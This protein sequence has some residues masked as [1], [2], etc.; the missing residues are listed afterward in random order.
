MKIVGED[1]ARVYG[2]Q[3]AR[4]SALAGVSLRIADGEFAAIIGRSGSGKSTLMNLV[5][6]L[7]TPTSGALYLDDVNTTDLTGDER[8]AIRNRDIGFVF[9]S[10]HL[11][12]RYS[13]EENVGLPLLYRKARR[14]DIRKRVFGVVEP[15]LRGNGG[16]IVWARWP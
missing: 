9:Q 3:S 2:A 12:P 10:Y 11:L 7:D 5:G 15:P 6:L 4:V 14:G 1:L 13:V 16:H 8:A